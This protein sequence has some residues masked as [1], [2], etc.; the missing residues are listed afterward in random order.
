[1]NVLRASIF[2]QV[3]IFKKI[4]N[5]KCAVKWFS[6]E[7]DDIKRSYDHLRRKLL[8]KP[9]PEE[10]AGYTKRLPG[11]TRDL[12]VKYITDYHEPSQE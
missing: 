1:M 9:T 7:E 12:L 4:G 2:A 8:R 11:E 10:V 6:V 5:D 3:G